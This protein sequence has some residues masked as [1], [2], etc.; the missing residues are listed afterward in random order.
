[1]SE[2]HFDLYYWRECFAYYYAWWFKA[3]Y[4][5]LHARTPP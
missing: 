2:N 5:L 1:M 4:A 3:W